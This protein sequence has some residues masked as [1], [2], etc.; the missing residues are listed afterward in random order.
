MPN[1][2]KGPSIPK[3]P[4]EGKTSEEIKAII[5]NI[6]PNDVKSMTE[7][8]KSFGETSFIN[9][10]DSETAKSFVNAIAEK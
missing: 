10:V 5:D 7:M 6:D 2:E 3:N 9:K 8:A 4:Y 1:L